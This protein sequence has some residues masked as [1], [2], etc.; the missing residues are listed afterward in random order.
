MK[1]T[2]K[3][4]FI[5]SEDPFNRITQSGIAF[6]MLHSLKENFDQVQAIGPIPKNK[7][8]FMALGAVKKI[9]ESVSSKRYHIG[10][11]LLL[12]RYYA[13]MIYKQL[14]DQHYDLIFAHGVAC[15][16]ACLKTA[17]PLFFS[18]DSSFNQL[19]DY[20]E[21][22]TGLSAIAILESNILEKKA[23]SNADI[24]IHSSKWAADYVKEYYNIR[25]KPVFILPMGANIDHAPDLGSIEVKFADMHCCNLLFIGVDWERKGG[26][27]AYETMVALNEAGLPT[28]LTVCGCLPPEAFKHPKMKVY[29]FLNKNIPG[30]YTIFQEL[31][32]RSH[33]LIFPSRAE[34]QGVAICEASAYGIPTIASDT[35]GIAGVLEHGVN[36]YQ[37]G[38]DAPAQEYALLIETLFEDVERYK[39]LVWK[40]RQKYEKELNWNAWGR[41]VKKIIETRLHKK[42]PVE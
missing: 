22:Y 8:F 19:K 37:L 30:D 17:L 21:F 34:C 16:I 11:S 39:K 40:S 12:S 38:L 2:L 24:L 3:I 20:Y 13:H 27:I 18:S 9:I 28:S 26:E 31:L 32:S 14:Q 7:L 6:Q 1:S 36:G 42:M 4:A 10:H 29:P 33:F 15:E 23:L 35:G 5:T 25:D 41:S